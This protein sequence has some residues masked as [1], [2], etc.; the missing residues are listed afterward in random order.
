MVVVQR[1][2]E[3]H[4]DQLPARSE[5][6]VHVFHISLTQDG[7]QRAE[8]GLLHDHVVVAIVREEVAGDQVVLREV[9]TAC[10]QVREGCG[11]QVD[12]EHVPEAGLVQE[13]RFVAPPTTG[14]QD[15]QVLVGQLVEV[16]LQGRAH[17]A[18]VPTRGTVGVALLP[19]VAVQ[20]D[21][22]FRLINR[23]TFSTW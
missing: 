14:D 9:R 5:Q 8:E 16:G 2:V 10:Q 20:V 19:E 4:T 23:T 21:H 11:C 1:I 12:H 18:Q 3:E 22:P 7:V 15:A 17:R 13:F 6:L